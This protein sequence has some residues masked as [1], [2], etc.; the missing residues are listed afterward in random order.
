MRCQKAPN[1]VEVFVY[2]DGLNRPRN[3]AGHTSRCCLE[4]PWPRRFAPVR[5]VLCPLD[6]HPLAMWLSG[7]MFLRKVDATRDRKT[8]EEET[9]GKNSSCLRR[10]FTLGCRRDAVMFGARTRLLWQRRE[11]SWVRPFKPEVCGFHIIGR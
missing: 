6:H 4:T 5:P 9:D 3:H 7:L 11:L 1:I 10:T 2:N 8:S